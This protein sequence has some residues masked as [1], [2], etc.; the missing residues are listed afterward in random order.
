MEVEN[1]FRWESCPLCGA[2]EMREIGILDYCGSVQFST[3]KIDL[4]HKPE[5]WAC[6]GCKSEFT[7][8]IIPETI[9]QALYSNSQAGDRWSKTPFVEYKTDEVVSVM[10]E[11]F[12]RGCRVLDV[13]CNTGEL[14]DYARSFG[15]QTAG[16]E[17][18]R[19]SR[20]IIQD[21]GHDAYESFDHLDRQFEVI[22]AFD[23]VEHLY[24]VSDFLDRCH[25]KLVTG[26]VLAILTGDV[27]SKSAVRAKAHWWYLQYPEHI[28][29][30]VRT[31]FEKLD[32]FRLQ[33]WLATYG[34]Q[35]YNRPCYRVWLS[36]IK[37]LLTGRIYNG[38]PSSGPDHALV[39]LQKKD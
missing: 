35:G 25:A 23:L 2:I 36:R 37:S 28:V 13:G 21:K 9:A 4:K 1:N 26:G 5:I 27:K 19:K 22:T 12:K 29:Y 33:T 3:Q 8:N 38:L 24:N 18:S 16:L 6:T 14:L 34:A 32:N 10:A 15:C 11:L 17:Y 30:P 7:Q 39:V 31:Y 20:E